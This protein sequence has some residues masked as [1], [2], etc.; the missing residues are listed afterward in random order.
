MVL[1]GWSLPERSQTSIPAGLGKRQ[2]LRMNPMTRLA[3]QRH[4]RSLNLRWRKPFRCYRPKHK[5]IIEPD[6]TL[7]RILGKTETMVNTVHRQAIS[8]LANGLT[9]EARA[10]DGTIEAVSVDGASGF[11]ISVQWH[12]EYRAKDNPDSV[13]LF[14]AFGDAARQRFVRRTGVPLEPALSA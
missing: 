10:E 8:R 14:E 3:M 4:S 11:N 6:S 13:K 2:R 9:V 7:H 1:T 12:P 5:I